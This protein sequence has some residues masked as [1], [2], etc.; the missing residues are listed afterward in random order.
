M[1]TSSSY[2]LGF[3]QITVC[4]ELQVLF[5][6]H[7]D[8][9]LAVYHFSS[10]NVTSRLITYI[11]AN[12]Q[13][14]ISPSFLINVSLSDGS[15]HFASKFPLPRRI[16]K[17]FGGKKKRKAERHTCHLQSCPM[18]GGGMSQKRPSQL[19]TAHWTRVIR[20]HAVALSSHF[21]P[22]VRDCTGHI[23]TVGR[24]LKGGGHSCFGGE[25]KSR[26]VTLTT[27]TRY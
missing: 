14:I 2:I 3:Q 7:R 1:L 16:C 11:M 27:D 10:T 26:P 5:D 15:C 22:C 20:H 19:I 4:N 25:V 6:E 12:L 23:K 13:L 21:R 24:S 17:H 9:H 18:L 8:E